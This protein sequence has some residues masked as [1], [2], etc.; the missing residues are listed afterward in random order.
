M[1]LLAVLRGDAIG[2]VVLM[3]DDQTVAELARTVQEAACVYVARARPAEVYFHGV[4]LDPE[5]TLTAAGLAALDRV[6]VVRGAE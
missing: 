4:A 1:P 6:D 5:A 2:M 3:Q